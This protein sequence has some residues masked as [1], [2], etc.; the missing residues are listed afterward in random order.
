MDV[1]HSI[2]LVH[3]WVKLAMTNLQRQTRNEQVVSSWTFF[4]LLL[5]AAQRKVLK[6]GLALISGSVPCH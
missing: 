1:G 5:H 4:N 3:L 2:C 6:T